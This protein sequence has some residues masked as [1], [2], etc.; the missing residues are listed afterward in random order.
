VLKTGVYQIEQSN[1]MKDRNNNNTKIKHK[2]VN[3]KPA[4]SPAQ[5]AMIQANQ[6]ELPGSYPAHIGYGRPA[7]WWSLGI[8]IYEM[9]AGIPAFRGNDLRQ[10]YQR[11]AINLLVINE[12]DILCLPK[13]IKLFELNLD[14][15]K[16]CS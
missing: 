9:I 1:K 15:K 5:T 3:P 10:T 7:D 11:W 12:G 16:F 13:T 14:H 2:T 6:S 8:M 4:M